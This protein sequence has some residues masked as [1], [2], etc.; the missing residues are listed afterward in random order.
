MDEAG[1]R[2]RDLSRGRGGNLAVALSLELVPRWNGN[3]G[4]PLWGR[5]RVRWGLRAERMVKRND[6]RVFVLRLRYDDER[7]GSGR[8]I[9][10][11]GRR[12]IHL[13]GARKRGK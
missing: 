11:R 6:E 13:R 12:R 9:R 8:Q 3:H 4:R 2:L 7:R 10:K 1:P 5:R